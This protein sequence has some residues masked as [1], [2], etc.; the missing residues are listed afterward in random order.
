MHFGRPCAG[1]SLR[2]KRRSLGIRGRHAG[3]TSLVLGGEEGSQMVGQV[4]MTGDQRLAID[5]HLQFNRPQVPG[6]DLIQPLLTA[7]K[8]RV[9]LSHETGS[10]VS[11]DG[12]LL[13]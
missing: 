7:A 5:R 10:F 12:E 2:T 1:C 3:F 9:V 6:D 13:T 4:R 11:R 8:G